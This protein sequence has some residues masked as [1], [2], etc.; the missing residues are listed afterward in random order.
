MLGI[1]VGADVGNQDSKF[2]SHGKSIVVPS[3]ACR[4]RIREI[5]NIKDEYHIRI[6][7]EMWWT[8][9]LARMEY[10]SREIEKNKL[11]RESNL[12]LILT[13]IALMM[14]DSESIVSVV[15]STPISD[16]SDNTLSLRDI[17]KGTWNID[18]SGKR[19]TIHIADALTMPEGA[20]VAFALVMDDNGRA[21]S[22][23]ELLRIIDIGSKTT[24]FCTFRKMK[25]IAAESGT[26]PF[27]ATSAQL[28]TYRRV[29][30]RIDIMPDDVTPDESACHNLA[31]RIRSEINKWWRSWDEVHLAGGGAMLL[32]DNLDFPIVPNPRL[33]TAIGNFR[34]G[35]AKWTGQ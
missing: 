19:K 18:L 15:G 24:N 14:P 21:H 32:R 2:Y 16:Y 5:D 11:M 12:P 1:I 29:A 22:K 20:S 34:V 3:Y 7:N 28:E 33:A 27:G 26:L 6:N 30:S 8:G 25:Y 35:V 23:P 31:T 10:A 9:D 4:E 17:I 13:G